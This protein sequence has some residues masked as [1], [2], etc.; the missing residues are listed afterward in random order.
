MLSETA[1][2]HCS[3][4]VTYQRGSS[5]VSLQAVIGKSEGFVSREFGVREQWTCRDF[6]CAANDLVLD[7]ERVEP[8]RGDRIVETALDENDEP[9]ATITHEVLPPADKEPCWVFS[10]PQRVRYRVHTKQVQKVPAS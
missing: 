3:Q 4:T 10:D 8:M 7:G 2:E 9:V 5:S 1:R 6:L